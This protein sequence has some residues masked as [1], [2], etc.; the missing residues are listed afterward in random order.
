M[1]QTS[2]IRRAVGQANKTPKDFQEYRASFGHLFVHAANVPSDR[3]PNSLAALTQVTGLHAQ[4]VSTVPT[5]EFFLST[6]VDPFPHHTIEPREYFS[7]EL[8]SNYWRDRIVS[9]AGATPAVIET[10]IQGAIGRVIT[11]PT[12]D[13]TT[14]PGD[15]VNIE[16]PTQEPPRNVE[17]TLSGHLTQFSQDPS[18]DA[19]IAPDLVVRGLPQLVFMPYTQPVSRDPSVGPPIPIH[20]IHSI[21]ALSGYLAGI[22]REEFGQ[23]WEYATTSDALNKPDPVDVFP[24]IPP[25]LEALFQ[26][27]EELPENWNSYGAARIS[28]WSITEAR[29]ITDEGI[30]LGLPVPAVSPASGS[31]VGIEW[32]TSNADL[33][34]D[35]DPQQGITYLIVDRT[36][37][38]EI[39]GELNAGNRSEVL[40]KVMGL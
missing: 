23:P 19:G 13:V 35:V 31:S 8:M 10:G 30:G 29:S 14:P 39:E 1:L 20:D 28:R 9:G 27:I 24:H 4:E 36:S 16:A 11:V 5:R 34:I 3:W 21:A 38:V 26:E 40:R 7:S 12:H 37:G 33:I 15:P 22:G 2:E 18:T 6:T 32:Q 25:Q 17:L